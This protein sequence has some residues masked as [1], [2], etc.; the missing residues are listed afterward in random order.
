MRP[1]ESQLN[2]HS[3]FW[4][5]DRIKET[6]RNEGLLAGAEVSDAEVR[7]AIFRWLDMIEKM[8][9]PETPMH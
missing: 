5:F 7:D 3:H 4:L 8:R 1:L 9:R 2:S 6:L